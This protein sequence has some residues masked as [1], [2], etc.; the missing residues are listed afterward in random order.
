MSE[1]VSFAKNSADRYY[2]LKLRILLGPVNDCG[3]FYKIIK[4]NN[5]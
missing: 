5:L 4:I 1:I 3:T 2:A